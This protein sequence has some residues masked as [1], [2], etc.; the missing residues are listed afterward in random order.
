MNN[1][2]LSVGQTGSPQ[3]ATAMVNFPLPRELRDE[4]YS[5][6]LDARRVK[7]TPPPDRKAA[8]S[9]MY[10]NCSGRAHTYK[11]F[12]AVLRVNKTIGAEATECL[13]ARQAFILVSFDMP[14]FSR[15]LHM[16]NVPIIA[17]DKLEKFKRHVVS[18][19]VKWTDHPYFT[20][21][22]TVHD[23]KLDPEQGFVLMLEVEFRRLC[24]MLR[25]LCQ[26]TL[27][28]C[29]YVT[30]RA[31]TELDAR[32]VQATQMAHIKVTYHEAGA[33]ALSM[34]QQAGVLRTLAIVIGGG[35]KLSLSGFSD[36]SLAR[37]VKATMAPAIAWPRALEWDRL[38]TAMQKKAEADELANKGDWAGAI[39]RYSV[40]IDLQRSSTNSEF[41]VPSRDVDAVGYAAFKH[42]LFFV[43][44]LY[45]SRASLNLRT[46]GNI[47]CAYEDAQRIR[48]IEISRIAPRMLG[49]EFHIGCLT[50][51]FVSSRAPDALPRLK[52]M[53]HDYI[54]LLSQYLPRDANAIHDQQV[55][56]AFYK[57]DIT[58]PPTAN[59]AFLDQLSPRGLPWQ[60]FD[61]QGECSEPTRPGNLVAWQDTH[62]LASLSCQ[63]K[64][65]I[66]QSKKANGLKQSKF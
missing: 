23:K 57:A 41:V 25:F 58:H 63:D 24:E 51:F 48:N 45:K 49:Q 65:D 37:G 34:P 26:Y 44:D 56:S 8:H 27:P 20:V 64:E 66:K 61:S 47:L 29:V 10:S 11:F 15:M 18:V 62:H 5:Y 6:L 7:Y 60:P 17:D 55:I 14:D 16:A 2:T 53:C 36:H 28:R 9:K 30:S 21:A 19:D 42:G 43:F 13:Y 46:G 12:T 22:Q 31:D 4:I 52:S 32:V 40:L 54:S 59:P 33:K 35:Y 3:P 1:V 39:S 50:T 38:E